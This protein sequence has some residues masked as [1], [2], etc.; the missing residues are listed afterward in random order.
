VLETRRL[1]SGTVRRRY[2]LPDGSA[3]TTYEVSEAEYLRLR[4]R[5]ERKERP[6]AAPNVNITDLFKLWTPTTIKAEDSHPSFFDSS[7]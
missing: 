3:A 4:G 2:R 1:A 5:P 7:I 6:P